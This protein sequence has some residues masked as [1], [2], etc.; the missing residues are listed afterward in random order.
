MAIQD[1]LDQNFTNAVL[2]KTL[3]GATK[4]RGASANDN[5]MISQNDIVKMSNSFTSLQNAFNKIYTYSLNVRNLHQFQEKRLQVISKET[6]LEAKTSGGVSIP[7]SGTQN[8]LGSTTVLFDD[9]SK[10][11]DNLNDKLK[12]TNLGGSGVLGMAGGL[13][14]SGLGA[15]GGAAAGGAI[16]GPAGAAIG[17][18]IGSVTGYFTG[19]KLGD[20]VQR[21]AAGGSVRSGGTYLV[22]ERG[23]EVITFNGASG[24]I[25]PNGQRGKTSTAEKYLMS[26]AE[27]SARASAK[28]EKGRPVGA[29]SYSSKFSNYLSSLF[30]SVPNWVSKI[31]EFFNPSTPSPTLGPGLYATV[32]DLT[33][34]KGDWKKDT[35]FI[36]AVNRVAQNYSIDANDLLGLMYNESAGTMSPSIRGSNG[37]TGL[38]Q[39]MPQY[40]DTNSIAK[41]SRAEQVNLAEEKIFKANGLPRGANAGQLYA[42]VFLPGIARAQNW[43]GVLSRKGDKYYGSNPGL[44]VAPKDNQI[45]IFDLAR[46]ISE[47]RSVMGLGLSPSVGYSGGT[48]P[49]T[50]FYSPTKKSLVTSSGFGMRTHP[51][52][53]EWSDHK[54]LDIPA[55]TGDP[56]YAVKAGVVTKA[57]FS[58]TYGNVVYVDHGEN[59]ETRYAHLSAILVRP[60]QSVDQ[61]VILGKAGST[62]RSTGPH[63]H[64][65][66]R[67]NGQSV[68][69]TPFLQGVAAVQVPPANVQPK[70][71][72][73]ILPKGFKRVGGI[74]YTPGNWQIP[75]TAK[76]A[77]DVPAYRGGGRAKGEIELYFKINQ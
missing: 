73:I 33:K 68:D 6:N 25:T 29:T 11:I 22:G 30:T 74:V 20:N 64:F 1:K 43:Q 18:F 34:V 56:I 7:S 23:P 41:M 5:T 4:I 77:A 60:G 57:Y 27:Q 12:N 54:G 42:S 53:K 15:R 36:N 26:A 10:S 47:K 31:K 62:G 58:D 76:K 49:A 51:I 2:R 44:D 52:T 46:V 65:E 55:A 32:G 75:I 8:N 63:L 40:F 50:G 19:S 59:V 17:G 61:N 14:G 39:F 13:A 21:R 28:F 69:P 66:I 48:P 67:I 3:I 9:L 38:F 37:A 71:Q 45:D 24:R 70:T 35:D 72:E 16:G